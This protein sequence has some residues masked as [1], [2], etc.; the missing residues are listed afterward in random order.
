MWTTG[1]SYS[2]KK[3]EAASL[4]GVGWR[5]LV[6]GLIEEGGL[7]TRDWNTQHQTPGLENAGKDTYGKPNGVLHV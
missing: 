4:N 5:Q 1:F 6:C 2:W 3:M 7:K